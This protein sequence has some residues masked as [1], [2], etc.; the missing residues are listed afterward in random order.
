MTSA[1]CTDSVQLRVGP[2][3]GYTQLSDLTSS[4]EKSLCTPGLNGAYIRSTN[5]AK[6]ETKPKLN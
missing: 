6:T 3:V 5:S 2:V 1:E 4:E